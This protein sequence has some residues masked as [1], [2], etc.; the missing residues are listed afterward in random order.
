MAANLLMRA[1]IDRVGGFNPAS[2]LEAVR[3]FVELLLQPLFF[4]GF[5]AYFV[6]GLVWFRVVASA[7]LNVAYPILVSATFILVSGGAILIFGEPFSLRKLFGMILILAGIAIVSTPPP[8]NS[9][10]TSSNSGTGD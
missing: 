3:G 1:G 7:P 5:L 2:A 6:A 9:V 4:L 10:A 8:H